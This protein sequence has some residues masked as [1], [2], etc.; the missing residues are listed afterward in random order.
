MGE[1]NP[2]VRE[3]KS[4]WTPCYMDLG[5]ENPLVPVKVHRHPERYPMVRAKVLFHRQWWMDHQALRKLVP[6]QEILQKNRQKGDN[7]S[8]NLEV[9]PGSLASTT[10]WAAQEESPSAGHPTEEGPKK[11]TQ[12]PH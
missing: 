7:N 10:T 6:N 1:E 2:A 9:F 5:Q 4:D 11:H 12:L 3:F 8:G